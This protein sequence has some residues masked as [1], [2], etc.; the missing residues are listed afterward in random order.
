MSKTTKINPFIAKY[1][2]DLEEKIWFGG[3]SKE[4]AI[5]SAFHNLLN[6]FCQNKGFVLV[7]EINYL[8]AKNRPDGTIKDNLSLDWGYWEAKDTSDNLDQEISKKLTKGYPD[9]NII[10]EDSKTAVLFQSGEEVMRIDMKN[11][12]ELEKIL[13]RMLSYKRPEVLDFEK[14]IL[15]FSENIPDIVKALR[16]MILEQ[17]LGKNSF[18]SGGSNRD[19]PNSPREGWTQSG[20]GVSETSNDKN[21]Y[22]NKLGTPQEENKNQPNNAFLTKQAEFLVLCR[23]AINPFITPEDV[24]EMLIQH[25]LTEDIFLSVFDETQ[26]H[27]ENNIASQLFELEQ[28][29]LKGQTKRDLLNSIEK[30]YKIIRARASQISDH[31]EKQKFLKMVYENFYKHYNPDKA[32]TLGVVYTPNEIV[33][34]IIKGTDFFSNHHF[35]KSLADKEV[36]I[37][38]P[39]TGTGTFI[40]EL[41]DFLPSQSVE[42]KYKNEIFCNEIAILPYYVA[43]LN[44]EYTY[45]Q[46]TGKYQEFTNIALVDTLD[47][48]YFG[49]KYSGTLADDMFG[50]VSLENSQRI[51]RQNDAKISIILGN[52]PYNANQMNFNDNNAN[53]TYPNVDQRIKDTYISKSTAQKT[54]V[55]D[56]YARF[57][58]WAS[59]RLKNNGIV[60]FV[61]NG[62]FIN[63]KTFD[64]FRRDAYSEFDYIYIVDCG[65]DIRGGDTTGNVFNI[66]T[67]VAIA[68][69]VKKKVD[70]TLPEWSRDKKQCSLYYYRLENTG[71]ENKLNELW[72]LG[73]DFQR[74]PFA[75]IIP[76]QK[77]NWIN[78]TDNDWS[79][80]I[81]VSTKSKTEKAIFDLYSNGVATNRDFW[82]YDL[83]KENLIKKV[84]YFIERYNAQVDKLQGN[85]PHTPVNKVKVLAE[86]N[87]PVN[88]VATPSSGGQ[89]SSV[90]K[91]PLLRGQIDRFGGIDQTV[92]NSELNPSIKWSESLKNHLLRKNRLTFDESKIV[93]SNYR[94]F[95]EKWFY[96]EKIM[97]DR[98]TQNHYDMFGQNLDLENK[99]IVYKAGR[100]SA[101]FCFSTNKI[102]D[103][104][105]NGGCVLFPL[106]RYF[107]NDDGSVVRLDNITDWALEIFR[108]RYGNTLDTP[109]NCVA[110]PSS[111]GQVSSVEK[112]PTQAGGFDGV[113]K[114]TLLRGQT[115]RFGGIQKVSS[116]D[117][118][119]GI[120]EAIHYDQNLVYTYPANTKLVDRS[121]EMAKNMTKSERKIWFDVLKKLDTKWIKQRIIGNYIIDFFCF[122][123][124]LAI[125]IDG[126]SH[127]SQIEY[128]QVRT[129]FLNELSITVIRFT[130]EEVLN[131]LEGV[132]NSVKNKIEQLRNIYNLATHALDT[133]VNKVKVLAE[134]NTPVNCVATPSSG[135]QV[136]SVEKA[137]L[138]RGQTDRFGGIIS[139]EDIFHYIYGILHD[140]KYRAKYETNLK[141]DFPRILFYEDF[142]QWSALGKELVNL[143]LGIGN[144]NSPHEGW[145][146]S[147]RGVPEVSN[148]EKPQK[149]NKNLLPKFKID[150]IKGEINLD[151]QTKIIGIPANVW[152]YKLG[153]RSAVEWILD[154]YKSPTEKTEFDI[155]NWSEIKPELIKLL[156]KIIHISD[157][158]IILTNETN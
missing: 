140:P 54:K 155:Y 83:N 45:K 76:D 93:K 127:N 71:K 80:L 32:D 27:R 100:E 132:F 136:S 137:P 117:R 66:M 141:Q 129:D 158:T 114:V 144:D 139:K 19:T 58:R 1:Y 13:N 50:T 7:D 152:D 52:P 126:D 112:V 91:A 77:A 34:F 82:V 14:A 24:Q 21:T 4:G 51:K 124:G 72:Q 79:S 134:E 113:E 84:Q 87:T 92:D 104:M 38:D 25:I 123:I 61:T 81:P 143:H 133:P 55:Y 98:L 36:E 116:E 64:G 149:E 5:R 138:L 120:D 153:N 40:T 15:Q 57:F 128:D 108:E 97:S 17:T 105:T 99:V 67:G 107:K 70:M 8:T 135:G 29:F 131:N 89:V 42:Y 62:S 49:G 74:L 75:K 115:D 118:S 2:K 109:V 6:S 30:Y 68:F 122:E 59:D 156:Q 95:V 26:F 28:T 146:Q 18:S 150:K 101:S 10:F 102:Q 111:E 125:E 103:L 20:R 154:Q 110:T 142:W 33:K 145:T 35:G 9:D 90:E 130:N 41:I 44:I 43:N 88:C 47:N 121:K 157:Q 46:K 60:A 73:E 151:D 53:R 94:P 37:L 22:P 65:G 16:E 85:T 147:G 106:Y 31:H 148:T 96:S 56:M 12:V 63:S 78:Q 39:A 119:K 11:P 23:E 69:L 48:V 86:E 3:T